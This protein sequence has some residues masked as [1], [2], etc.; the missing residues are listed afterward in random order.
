MS[1]DSFRLFE[2][3]ETG[4]IPIVDAASGKEDFPEFWE[5]I[6]GPDR[7]LLEV[8]DWKR[9]PS[10]A[11]N[12]LKNYTEEVNK[13][14]GWW[15]HY[16]RNLA[17]KLRDRVNEL[18]GHGGQGELSDRI[19]ILMPTSPI[20]SHPDTRVIEETIESVRAQPELKDAEIIVMLDGV[21]PEQRHRCADY[22]EFCRRLLWLCNNQWRNVIVQ[23]HDEHMHQGMMTKVA[24][25]TMVQTEMIL[26][27]EQ[28]TPICDHIEWEGMAE[29]IRTKAANAIRLHHEALILPDHEHLMIGKALT[30]GGIRMR[31]TQ[32]WSQRP[33]L[34]STEFYRWMIDTYFGNESRTMIE[35]VM[36]SVLETHYR[37]KEME[38]W[39]K[40]R[41]WIY[42]PKTDSIK[43][44]YHTDGREGESKYT[45][46]FAYDD[47]GAAM[48]APFAGEIDG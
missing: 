10:V 31:R 37:E 35:D 8:I 36:Y 7:P 41:L 30:R 3:L 29:A 21:R 9:A 25:N 22:E 19:T 32:Q 2:A 38:G 5:K 4:C 28:D 23:R 34:A 11:S 17:Y 42:T 46:T 12:A 15:Q 40:F 6:F 18:S 26:F 39:D 44:S 27:V 1:P 47:E 48:Y 24:L 16:K 33:H 14:F 13:V 45:M 20:K 43:R